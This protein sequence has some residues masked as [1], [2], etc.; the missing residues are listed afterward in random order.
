MK[1][2][3]VPALLWRE[4][5]VRYGFASLALRYFRE[6][7]PTLPPGLPVSRRPARPALRLLDLLHVQTGAASS[8]RARQTIRTLA[9]EIADHFRKSCELSSVFGMAAREFATGLEKTADQ[10]KM[11]ESR[12]RQVQQ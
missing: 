2:R 10:E 4:P 12:K 8:P 6:A 7:E 5:K 9:L 11:S 3:E 1:P